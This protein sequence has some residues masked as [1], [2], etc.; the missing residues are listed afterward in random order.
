VI[1]IVKDQCELAYF[2][3]QNYG[4]LCRKTYGSEKF[5]NTQLNILPVTY[6]NWT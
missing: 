6:E 3:P 2:K 1:H 5:Q 4:C